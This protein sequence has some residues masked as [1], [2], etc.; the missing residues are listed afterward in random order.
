MMSLLYVS[1]ATKRK[2]QTVAFHAN[3]KRN[4]ILK[5]LV[6]FG[7]S[8]LRYSRNATGWISR[9]LAL[10]AKQNLILVVYGCSV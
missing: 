2:T 3:H 4:Q 10:Q 5:I 7:V 1:P 6:E 8:W 9:L